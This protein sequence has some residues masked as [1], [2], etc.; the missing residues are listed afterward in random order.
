MNLRNILI[1]L[2]LA[3]IFANVVLAVTPTKPLVTVAGLVTGAFIGIGVSR[4]V[5][6]PIISRYS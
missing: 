3:I 5:A 2:I 6:L 4:F 1:T